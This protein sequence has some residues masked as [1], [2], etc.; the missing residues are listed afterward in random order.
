LV[1]L[2]SVNAFCSRFFSY[3]KLDVFLNLR[4]QGNFVLTYSFNKFFEEK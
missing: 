2:N 1:Q 3:K 4:E